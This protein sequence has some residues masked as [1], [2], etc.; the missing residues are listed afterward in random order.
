[1]RRAQYTLASPVP[2]MGIDHRRFDALVPWDLQ[3]VRA[4]LWR[5]SM[6]HV[7]GF[8]TLTCRTA[9]LNTL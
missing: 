1:M 7:A 8:A 5:R 3:E 4:K 6:W 2:D 9:S